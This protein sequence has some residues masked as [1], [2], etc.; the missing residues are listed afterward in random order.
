MQQ[1][2]CHHTYDTWEGL[3]VDRSPYGRSHGWTSGSPPF[4]ADGT[5]SKSGALGFQD[6]SAV[7][8][9]TTPAWEKL[10]TIDVEMVVNIDDQPHER[11]FIEGDRSFRLAGLRL[12]ADGVGIS[13]SAIE[14][15]AEIT[16]PS[17]A[18]ESFY[19]PTVPF[20]TWVTLKFA[21]DGLSTLRLGVDEET[22]VDQAS[23]PLQP[24]GPRGISIGSDLARRKPL[25]GY[26]DE[27]KVWR[28]D[29]ASVRN[30]FLGRPFTDATADCWLSA[31]QT[32]TSIVQERAAE[33]APIQLA[34]HDSLA[35][36]LRG[37]ARFGPADGQLLADLSARFDSL[38]RDGQLDT[39]DMESVL[40]QFFGWW[41]KNVGPPEGATG[42]IDGLTGIVRGIDLS[43]DPEYAGFL[44]RIARANEKSA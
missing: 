18:T 24:V 12:T 31:L 40:G 35:E 5:L 8:V 44:N 6:R 21:Y 29:P 30:G 32:L 25:G 22:K 14:L 38:W 39:D 36:Q 28:H 3:P 42:I 23:S 20:N 2:I 9:P 10:G 34:L 26:L 11:V 13:Y 43:C 1:L 15:W 17:G 19:G 16:T 41:N 7:F 37:L 27:I 4:L 33:L